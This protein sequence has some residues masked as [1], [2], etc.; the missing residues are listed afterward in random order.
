MQIAKFNGWLLLFAAMFVMVLQIMPATAQEDSAGFVPV[1]D[2]MLQAPDPADWL[3]GRRT[4]NSWGFSP[5]D[6]INRENV[7]EIRMVWSRDLAA[8]TGEVTPLAYG[9]VLYVPQAEDVIQAIDAATGE[10]SFKFTTRTRGP[11]SS[12][13]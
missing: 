3:M 7:D 1:T 9:G 6:Q 8:G 11:P 5:L 10:T 4:L 2:A 12:T 13:E